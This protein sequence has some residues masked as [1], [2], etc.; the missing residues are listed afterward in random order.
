M[1]I[2]QWLKFSKTLLIA[3][4]KTKEAQALD[5]SGRYAI[6]HDICKNFYKDLK[7]ETEF[8]GVENIPTD[9]AV[10]YISNHQGTFDP[11]LL[12]A[13]NPN[14]MTFISKKENL[15]L[16][17]IADWGKLIEFITFDREN[18]D[19]NVSMLRQ[20]TRFLKEGKSVLVFPEGTRAKGQTL[21]PFKSGAVL[22]AF[23]AKAKIIPVT[24][25]FG[26][27]CDGTDPVKHTLSVHFHP[28]LLP[29]NYKQKTHEEIM[30]E[31]VQIISSKLKS[32]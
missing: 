13:A 6:I 19:Q 16:P 18:F 28:A 26:F 9:E 4:L 27:E 12:I 17:V 2:S 3:K 21:L 5:F 8:T 14:P 20:A 23:L 10:Y 30:N 7:I 1:K 11:L 22:P 25:N 24:Q 32:N 29:E 31:C 15:K